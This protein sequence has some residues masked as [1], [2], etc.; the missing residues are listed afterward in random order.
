MLANRLKRGIDMLS[1]LRPY[2]DDL[3][4]RIDPGEEAAILSDWKAFADG[5]LRDSDLTRGI[6]RRVPRAPG[7][8]WPSPSIN[9]ALDSV[10]TMVISQLRACSD[11][12][13]SGSNRLMW[14][15]ANYGVGILPTL[16]GCPVFLM[17]EAHHC[18]PNVT[19]L[20][21]PERAIPALAQSPLPSFENGW[22]RQVFEVAEYFAQIRAQYPNIARYVRIDH[23]DCQGP[24]D[25]CELAWGSDIF[26]A[27]YDD[28][29]LV[30]GLM[31]WMTHLFIAFITRWFEIIPGTDQYHSYFGRLHRGLLTI[32]NDS[33]T[34]LSPQIYRDF[35]FPCDQRILRHFGGGMIH[36]CGNGGHFLPLM[37]ETEGLFAIDLSQPNLNNMDVAMESTIDRGINLH[38]CAGSFLD[39]LGQ[40]QN[41]HRL[42]C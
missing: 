10:Q 39:D 41:L 38:T 24:I 22:G 28:E 26:L 34:N 32:R 3:E 15:R 25:L 9:Q 35:I 2:L 17:D 31:D 14:M 40:R 29:D 21:D 4:A 11:I 37:C 30:R 16:F 13:V 8:E 1:P 23:P 5:T 12:L 42:S 6:A 19:A 20:P 18:L 36:F 7:I 27:F 33:A